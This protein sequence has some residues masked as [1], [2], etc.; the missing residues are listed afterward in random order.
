MNY[1]NTC[2]GFIVMLVGSLGYAL[3]LHQKPVYNRI[4]T[5]NHHSIEKAMNKIGIEYTKTQLEKMY[6]VLK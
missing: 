5:S 2:L 1:K 6:K 4:Y 3:G